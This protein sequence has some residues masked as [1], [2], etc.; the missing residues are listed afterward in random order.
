[1]E[2]KWEKKI[3]GPGDVA[4]VTVTVTRPAPQDP[5][6]LGVPLDPPVTQPA[7]GVD[8]STSFQGFFPYVFDRDITNADGKVRLT[9]KLP[10]SAKRGPVDSYTYASL[11]HN[12]QGP[13][14]SDFEEY[15]YKW[16]VPAVMVR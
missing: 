7:E 13:A 2:T 3:Y 6:G 12:A 10:P 9:L 11:L 5:L 16:D 14:C 8:V 15:G 1:V 4:R